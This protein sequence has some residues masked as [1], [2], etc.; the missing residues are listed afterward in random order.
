MA[1]SRYKLLAQ[2]LALV[3]FVALA[4]WHYLMRHYDFILPP[5]LLATGLLVSMPLQWLGR[6]RPSLADYLLLVGALILFAIEAPHTEQGMLWLGLP[7]VISFLLLSLPLALLLNVA[8]VPAWLI[9]L[10]ELHISA[11]NLSMGWWVSLTAGLLFVS[12][13]SRQALYRLRQSLSRRDYKLSAA[14][15]QESLEIEIARAKALGR[16]LSVL[17]LY[18]PQLDQAD[19]Q[20][21]SHLREAL[22]LAF[23]EVVS[24]NSRHSDLLGEYRSNVFCLVLPNSDEPGALVVAKRLAKAVAAISRPETGPLESYSRVCTL[25]NGEA[26]TH[27]INRLD[28]AATKLLEPRA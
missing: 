20:F 25:Q 27:F 28:A 11:I 26:A 12:F 1:V 3:L 18:I 14:N 8:L 7:A 24:H 9:M 19:D 10:G 15:L 5:A 23:S 6:L 13:T 2:L 17:V 22:S 4:F 21:G 16:P